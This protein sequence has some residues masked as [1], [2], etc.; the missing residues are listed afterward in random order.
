MHS[1]EWTT[2][3]RKQL[4]KIDN[5]KRGAIISAVETLKKFPDVQNVK[6]LSNHKFSYRLRVGRYRVFFSALTTIKVIRIDEVKK[7]DEQ[8]Y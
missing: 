6:T 7:R 5:S 1:I 3:S 4:K 8:T 2:K